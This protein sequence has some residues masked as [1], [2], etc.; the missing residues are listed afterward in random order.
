[1]KD[2]RDNLSAYFQQVTTLQV[3]EQ[4][5]VA[6]VEVCICVHV[7]ALSR[8]NNN[9][10]FFHYRT[11]LSH[12][13]ERISTPIFKTSVQGTKFISLIDFSFVYSSCVNCGIRSLNT[14]MHVG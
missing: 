1:M 8:T 2:T 13:I 6:V 11:S 3:R 14:C 9:K 12:K 7:T 4:K 5:L 10:T